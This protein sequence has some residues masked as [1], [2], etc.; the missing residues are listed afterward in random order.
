MFVCLC[1]PIIGTRNL[2]VALGVS[3]IG[4]SG[5][6]LY[7][8][9]KK[10]E[11]DDYL[12]TIPKTSTFKISEVNIP[13]DHIRDLIGRNGRT[14]KSIEHQSKTKIH[15]KDQND[16]EEHRT[17]VIK[18]TKENCAYA[19]NLIFE[20]ISKQPVIESLDIFV[21]QYCVGK[22]I[23][24]CGEN[25][26]ELV[27]RTGAKIKVSDEDRTTPTRRIIVKGLQDQVKL[28]KSYIEEIVERTQAQQ[29]EIDLSLSKREPRVPP[30]STSPNLKGH[31]S[32][33][34]ERISPIPGKYYFN[35]IIS[36]EFL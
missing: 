23:G 15:F 33:K 18:G 21:P 10:D 9:F 25:I 32:P 24:R 11:D 20:Y 2:T 7:L 27:N 26:M 6:L 13:K 19:E 29:S 34:C 1:R 28:A 31:E 3:L 16:K 4:V 14:I 35:T 8:L 36:I 12:E 5:Y 30:K 17:C 22:I